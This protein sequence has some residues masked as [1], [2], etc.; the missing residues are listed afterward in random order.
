M[1]EKKEERK[2]NSSK[3]GNNCNSSRS[4]N[5]SGE[6]IKQSN[7]MNLYD[8]FFSFQKCGNFHHQMCL[9]TR[10]GEKKSN[11]YMDRDREEAHI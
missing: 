8:F 3:T 4:S 9:P 5:N 6:I 11:T 10:R 1:K 7:A 2:K